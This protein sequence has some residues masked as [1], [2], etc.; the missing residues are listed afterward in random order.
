MG[1]ASE[2]GGKM[3]A[4]GTL[5]AGDGLW[6]SPNTSA[7][8]ISNFSGLPGGHRRGSGSF[9]NFGNYGAWWTTTEFNEA[10]TLLLYLSYNKNNIILTND[11]K[12]LGFSV[13]C[14]KD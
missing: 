3:K 6:Q 11:N 4:T 12:I 2:A 13:R 5:Q 10:S 9:I 1:G 14:V 8:N 7:T